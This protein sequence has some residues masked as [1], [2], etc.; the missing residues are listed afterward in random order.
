MFGATGLWGPAF[1]WTGFTVSI[2][3]IMRTR[4]VITRVVKSPRDAWVFLR[5]IANPKPDLL[6]P[7]LLDLNITTTGLW[8]VCIY[9]VYTYIYTCIS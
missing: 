8:Y 9:S 3:R 2:V 7:N 4:S 5:A 1:V 6:R